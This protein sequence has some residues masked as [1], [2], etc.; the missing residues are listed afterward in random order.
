M[1]PE[2]LAET[3]PGPHALREH[4]V[5]LVAVV[6]VMRRVGQDRVGWTLDETRRTKH[7]PFHELLAREVNFDPGRKAVPHV[8]HD[9]LAIKE[10]VRAASSPPI[11]SLTTRQVTSQ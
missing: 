2:G 1:T 10:H 9:P 5:L 8:R 3:E 6:P 4:Q 11:R 7:L